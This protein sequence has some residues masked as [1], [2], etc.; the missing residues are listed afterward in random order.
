MLRNAK[1]VGKQR[2]GVLTLPNP[3]NLYRA[4]QDTICCSEVV[5]GNGCPR[6]LLPF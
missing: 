4:D 3:G 1:E 2:S 6:T 5:I